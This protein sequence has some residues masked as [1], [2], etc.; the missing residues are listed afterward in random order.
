MRGKGIQLDDTGDLTIRVRRDGTGQILGGL[1]IGDTTFQN[2]EQ[3]LLAQP[4]TVKWA[5]LVGVGIADYLDDET[6]ENLLR[7][8]RTQL[9]AEGMKVR[10]LMFNRTGQ[11][12]IDAQYT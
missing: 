9:A 2:Q 6:P 8:V 3:L 4:G 12:E 7:T 5:P 11:L 1:A 10:S